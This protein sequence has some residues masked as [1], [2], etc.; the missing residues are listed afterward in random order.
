MAPRIGY[1]VSRKVGGA[2]ERNRVRRRLRELAR[3]V[4]WPRANEGC[5]YVLIGRRAA[6]QR[7][8]ARMAQDLARAL[9]KLNGKR[10]HSGHRQG[11]G[12]KK[13]R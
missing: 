2:V 3:Q 10:A 7:P 8:F 1:T 13:G 12:D 6:L 9:D 5:D 4:L 11:D